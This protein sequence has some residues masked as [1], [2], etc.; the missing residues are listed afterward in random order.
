MFEEHSEHCCSYSL[1][2]KRCNRFTNKIILH[3]NLQM[4]A[5]LI[6]QIT[7]WIMKVASL[8]FLELGY[9]SFQILKEIRFLRS[10]L[11][12][13][14][15][16]AALRDWQITSGLTSILLFHILRGG[17]L[18]R[19]FCSALYLAVPPLLT[20]LARNILLPV[21]NFSVSVSIGT[22]W[23]SSYWTS[24][25]GWFHATGFFLSSCRGFS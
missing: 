21:V 9:G 25:G 8:L 19:S 2:A 6:H 24:H 15:D 23:G 11:T 7:K 12:N 20:A 10:F 1:D 3:P 22:V 18:N 5:R 16:L 4:Y 14:D 13:E 17:T